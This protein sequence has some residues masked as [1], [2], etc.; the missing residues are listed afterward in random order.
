[1]FLAQHFYLFGAHTQFL[2]LT[3]EIEHVGT[4]RKCMRKVKWMTKGASTLYR[5]ITQPNC[6]VRV[7]KPPHRL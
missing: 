1:M 4:D 3:P 7:T 5:L 2:G 6:S